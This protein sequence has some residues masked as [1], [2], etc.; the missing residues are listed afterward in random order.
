M[1]ITLTY[2]SDKSIS[3][4]DILLLWGTDRHKVRQL[5]N[6]NFEIN[7]NVIDLSQYNNGDILQNIAQRRDIYRNY[8]GNENFFFL[9]FDNEDKL[10][11]IEIHY[12]LDININGE[13]I[14]FSMDIDEVAGLLDNISSDKKNLSDGE[15]FFQS[16]KLTIASSEAMGGD[17]NKLSY[18]YCSKDVTHLTDN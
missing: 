12:G 7:D 8:K 1:T 3:F 16:L 10:R 4:G 2:E 5:L 11:D 14:N 18:F 6:G 17:G 15:Y 9:N 13:V